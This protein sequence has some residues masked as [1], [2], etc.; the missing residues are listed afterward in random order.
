MLHAIN[1][2]ETQGMSALRSYMVKLNDEYKPSDSKSSRELIGRKEYLDIWYEVRDTKVEH[3][4]ISRVMSLV[5]QIIGAGDGSKVMVFTLYRDTCDMLVEKLSVIPGA[6]VAKLIGQSKGGLTQKAQIGILEEFRNGVFNVIV[7]TSVGE[8]GLDITSTNA[9]IFYEPVPSEIRT[10]QRRGRTGRKNDGEV[11]VL[12]A[13]DTIDEVF[14]KS[15]KNKEDLMR[16]RLEGLNATL[17]TRSAGS[18]AGNQK[19][20]GEF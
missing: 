7:S 20:I 3:P 19:R 8:E 18:R 2:A 4:K 14:E 16:S 1:L 12:I 10:I 15:S 5:S 9:V 6:T 11:F 17:G 13:K